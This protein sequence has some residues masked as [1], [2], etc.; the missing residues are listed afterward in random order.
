MQSRRISRAGVCVLLAM[1]L[2]TVL[3]F[4]T[5]GRDFAGYYNIADATEQ[6]DQVQLT[7]RVRIFNHSSQDLRQALVVLHQPANPGV[8]G[9][10]KPIKLLPTLKDAKVNQQVLVPRHVYEQ[11]QKGQA[12]EVSI[13]YVDEH[14]TRWE[15][16]I[17]LA[18]R[19]VS[20][21]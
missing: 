3:G 4:A 20:Y 6:G 17:Q 18:P 8:L 15:K 10:S 14:G 19:P 16:S 13:V 1:L 7:L 21:F 2:S 9:V 5:D 12:P 11:W